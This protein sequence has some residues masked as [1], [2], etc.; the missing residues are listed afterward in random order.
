[1]VAIDKL[2][3]HWTICLNFRKGNSRLAIKY[4]MIKQ[5]LPGKTSLVRKAM[6]LL[7]PRP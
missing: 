2:L 4:F 5:Q 6:A 7:G 3:V 1:M